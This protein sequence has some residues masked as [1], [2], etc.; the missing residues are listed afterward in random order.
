MHKCSK[1]GKINVF[2]NPLLKLHRCQFGHVTHMGALV[3]VPV[4]IS[5][6][7]AVRH[8]AVSNWPGFDT[9]GTLWFGD[10]TQRALD[11]AS[12]QAPMGPVG[13]LLPA[14]V[15]L[16]MLVTID[17]SFGPLTQGPPGEPLHLAVE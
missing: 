8:M 6:V 4:F 11:L 2:S 1:S 14:A 3:Q 16:L 9:G 5:A 13:V 12:L 17:S 10:L 7:W 15:V